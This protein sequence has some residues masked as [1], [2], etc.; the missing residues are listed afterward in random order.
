MRR[1]VLGFHGQAGMALLCFLLETTRAVP[2]DG[3]MERGAVACSV[4]GC[5]PAGTGLVASSLVAHPTPKL[6]LYLLAK[7]KSAEG[8]DLGLSSPPPSP[9]WPEPGGAWRGL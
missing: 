4:P 6:F 8:K 7:G 9:H 2:D 1:L 5:P 3:W